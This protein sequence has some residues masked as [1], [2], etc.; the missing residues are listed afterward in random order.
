MLQNILRIL[1]AT[2]LHPYLFVHTR[3]FDT[4]DDDNTISF[5]LQKI[6]AATA[7]LGSK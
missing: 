7:A 6:G 3:T 5:L 1:E 2:Y 4:K